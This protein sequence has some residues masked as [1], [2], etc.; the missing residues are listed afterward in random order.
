MSDIERHLTTIMSFHCRAAGSGAA[1]GPPAGAQD[2]AD[3]R[4]EFGG[5]VPA[6]LAQVYAVTS[7]G[8]LLDNELL[9][10]AGVIRERR[11]WEQGAAEPDGP[12]DAS[13]FAVVSLDPDAVSARYW[14]R[15]WVPFARDGGGNGYAVDL[16]PEPGGTVGQVINI[17][18]DEDFRAVVAL[19][20]ADCLARVAQLIS[21]GRVTV[22][23]S[24]HTAVD[25]DKMLLTALLEDPLRAARIIELTGA[26]AE[27]IAELRA[28]DLP[29][30][31]GDRDEPSGTGQYL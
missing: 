31:F 5:D 20:V 19:S 18:P 16:A 25:G 23:A 26:P 9:G 11:I 17:G 22:S 6:D 12:D 21:A 13:P 30:R 29:A 28:E 10:I 27:V 8:P 3:Y 1:Y 4:T 7:G 2:F 14:K 24:G 15:G